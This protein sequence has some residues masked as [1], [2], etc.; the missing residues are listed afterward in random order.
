M[1]CSPAEAEEQERLIPPERT[2]QG[3]PGGQY[4]GHQ[5]HAKSR[6]QQS[7]P[8]LSLMGDLRHEPGVPSSDKSAAQARW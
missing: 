1:E 6:R 8:E 7:Y 3:M 5:D 4:P 2:E